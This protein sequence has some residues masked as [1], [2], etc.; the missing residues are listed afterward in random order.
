MQIPTNLSELEDGWAADFQ[1][2]NEIEVSPK[3]SKFIYQDNK[4]LL[5]KSDQSSN[6]YDIL[7]YV[8]YDISKAEI[9]SQVRI[10]KSNS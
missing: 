9:P 8:R 10:V 3:N 4:Y 6:K 7:H 2:L 1:R 5:C